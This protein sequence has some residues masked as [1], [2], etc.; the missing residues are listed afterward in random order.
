MYI[1]DV[2]DNLDI[3]PNTY[4]DVIRFSKLHSWYKHFG[5]G[6][7]NYPALF[8]G[9]EPRMH[10]TGQ[11]QYTDITNDN[12]HWCIIPEYL[13]D[14]YVCK[15]DDLYIG[16]IPNELKLVLKRFPIV[17]DRYFGSRHSDSV[18]QIEEC[19]RVCVNF[20]KYIPDLYIENN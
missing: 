17:L 20:W 9:Q 8:I 3:M 18:R 19:E 11:E 14:T 10:I 12:Y 16:P 1:I 5:E 4:N 7:L 15:I 2:I 13:L 6:Q